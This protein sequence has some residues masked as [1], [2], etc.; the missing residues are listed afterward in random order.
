MKKTITILT[1]L[2]S[3]VAAVAIFLAPFKGWDDLVERSPNIFI[4]RLAAAR[5][6]PITELVTNR[7]ITASVDGVAP[8]SIEVLNVLKG[9]AKLGPA[10]VLLP[11][12]GTT[13]TLPR[14]GEMFLVFADNPSGIG[15]ANPMF[16]AVEDYRSVIFAPDRSYSGWTNHLAGKPLKE[17]IETILKTRLGAL[18]SE[19]ARDEAEKKRLD[20][21]V[22]ELDK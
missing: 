8:V 20:D 19:L 1:L 2:A 5:Q 14:P 15:T 13:Y 4:A 22:K 10:Q 3:T 16:Y 21:G 12:L 6:M 9:E 17:Q 11:I 18:N 7:Q